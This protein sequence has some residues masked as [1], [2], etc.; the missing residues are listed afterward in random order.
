MGTGMG[1]IRISCREVQ[2]K[3][4]DGHENEGEAVTHEIEVVGPSSK[5]SG[6]REVPKNQCGLFSCDFLHCRYGTKRQP[7][8]SKQET[9]WREREIIPV[10]KPS[11]QNSYCLQ[12]MQMWRRIT[13]PT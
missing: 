8:V 11:T 4:L 1:G 2:E 3:W 5:W 7:S 10:T 6:K 13:N 9:K 12:I